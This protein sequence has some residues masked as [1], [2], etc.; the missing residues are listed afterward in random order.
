LLD[1]AKG[2]YASSAGYGDVYSAV[3]EALRN[4]TTGS[5]MAMGGVVPGYA[6]GGMVG[7]G[8]FNID[9]VMARY[10]GGGAIGLAGGEYVMPAVQTR[11]NLPQLDAMRSGR[12]NDNGSR[13][14]GMA[15]NRQTEMQSRDSEELRAE[16]ASMKQ[17]IKSLNTKLALVLAAA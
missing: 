17:E 15:I 4:L 1:Q 8:V 13:E 11:Q 16:V 12:T 5:G 2:F 14:V 9:S 7:N 3:T 10:A 6:G